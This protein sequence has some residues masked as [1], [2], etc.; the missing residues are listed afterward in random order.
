MLPRTWEDPRD[1]PWE[2]KNSCKTRQDVQPSERIQSNHRCYY[3][4]KFTYFHSMYVVWQEGMNDPTLLCP[5]LPGNQ[6]H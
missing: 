4:S 5:G 2:K 3:L 6:L 1:K